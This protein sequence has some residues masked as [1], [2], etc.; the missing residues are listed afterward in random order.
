MSYKAV[1]AGASGLIGS[2]LLNILLNAPEYSE[3]TI[4]VRKE[5]ALQHKK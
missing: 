1:I 3:V 4:L 5:I 2:N